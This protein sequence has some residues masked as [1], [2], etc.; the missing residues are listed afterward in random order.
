MAFGGAPACLVRHGGRL[1]LITG[2]NGAEFWER[3]ADGKWDSLGNASGNLVSTPAI[4]DDR[5]VSLAGGHDGLRLAI[6][7]PGEA[8]AGRFEVVELGA[9]DKPVNRLLPAYTNRPAVVL[10]LS[11]TLHGGTLVAAYARQKYSPGGM[12]CTILARRS[13]DRGATWSEEAELSRLEKLRGVPALD[14][15]SGGGKLHAVGGEAASLRH[16]I[17]DDDGKTWKDGPALPGPADGK[18]FAALR[19]FPLD[20]KVFLLGAENAQGG[21]VWLCASRD[22]GDTWDQPRAL[23]AKSS[24]RGTLQTFSLSASGDRLLLSYGLVYVN[25]RYDPAT[26]S[27]S[28]EPAAEGGLLASADGGVTWQKQDGLFA[29]LTGKAGGA[30]CLPG[31]DGGIEAV[32]SWVAAN[33]GSG[34]L[35]YR[36]ASTEPEAGLDPL[37]QK[38]LARL[39]AD[40]AADDYR[41][42]EQ[43]AAGLLALGADALPALQ[44]AARDKDPERSLTAQDLLR[45]AGPA[46]LKSQ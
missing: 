4:F 38:E 41:V 46:W 23:E 16:W 17:S 5:V 3:K 18:A 29:G 22:G 43:A 13:A 25:S 14:L 21:R 1:L 11:L 27:H 42:R 20:G 10:S 26:G 35:L 36:R 8:G 6:M 2:G 45:R 7:R 30:R 19:I 37:R 12:T 32:F 9:P 33:G 44:A 40:L 24:Q 15:W 39:V 31:P 34:A 28:V